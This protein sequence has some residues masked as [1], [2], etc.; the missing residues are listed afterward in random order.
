MGKID[1]HLL[2]RIVDLTMM[3]RFKLGDIRNSWVVEEIGM[4]IGEAADAAG[5]NAKFIRHYESRSIIP[6]AS[7]AEN[8]YRSFTDNDVHILRF[9]KH[10]R[11]LGF[12]LVEIKKLVSLWRNKSRKSADVKNIAAQHIEAL[13]LKIKE[14]ISIRSALEKLS[15]NCHGDDRPDCPILDD[16]QR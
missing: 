2:D 3:V 1:K 12:S 8:G 4:N 7:R 16:L 5:V 10:A 9:V 14:L 6:K 13:D 15:K 11:N